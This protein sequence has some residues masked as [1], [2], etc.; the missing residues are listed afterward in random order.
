MVAFG[1]R[2]WNWFISTGVSPSILLSFKDD[3]P[4]F[5]SKNWNVSHM[6]HMKNVDVS[7]G[8]MCVC[9]W[10]KIREKGDV[11]RISFHCISS[12]IQRN[13]RYIFTRTGVNLESINW[14]VITLLTTPHIFVS[15]NCPKSSQIE[16]KKWF[17]SQHPNWDYFPLSS[18]PKHFYTPLQQKMS[19]QLLYLLF[20]QN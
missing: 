2:R 9:V 8:R 10:K 1:D 7:E 3:G 4:R 17:F 5:L 12:S 15:K 13:E 20:R 11:C 18:C 16:D 19:S 14:E 6:H